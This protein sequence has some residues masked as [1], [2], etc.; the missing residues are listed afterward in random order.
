M[1][2][3]LLTFL[4]GGVSTV[5]PPAFMR[6]LAIVPALAAWA[7]VP[8]SWLVQLKRLSP[9]PQVLAVCLVAVIAFAN[10]KL[11]FID[12]PVQPLP[13][14][15]STHAAYASRDLA[16]T[17]YKLYWLGLPNISVRYETIRFL[18]PNV[19]G[20]DIDIAKEPVPASLDGRLMS[21]R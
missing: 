6:I 4:I 18:A 10:L 16:A 5:D 14:V 13:T 2:L 15:W 8:L 21:F 1:T 17:G 11:Y 12:Y 20:V 7:S 3:F 9:Y 19:E